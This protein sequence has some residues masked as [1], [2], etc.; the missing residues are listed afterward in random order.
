[1]IT[2]RIKD[3]ETK[4]LPFS[5]SEFLYVT[6]EY[7]EDSKTIVA[8]KIPIALT[9]HKADPADTDN[10]IEHLL[11]LG[12]YDDPEKF[13]KDIVQIAREAATTEQCEHGYW[14]FI[15]LFEF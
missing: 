14:D 8:P 6:V 2:M 7:S 4:F 15:P 3:A 10:T 9:D 5:D 13:K 11:Q 1:M 12:E